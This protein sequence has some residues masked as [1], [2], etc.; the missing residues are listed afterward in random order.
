[1][2]CSTDQVQVWSLGQQ[3]DVGA[4]AVD[5]RLETDLVPSKTDK[6]CDQPAGPWGGGGGG[7]GAAEAPYWTMS[8]LVVKVNG[9]SSRVEMA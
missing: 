6:S 9:R 4:A 2:W 3:L 7:G 5:A 1:M 8:G